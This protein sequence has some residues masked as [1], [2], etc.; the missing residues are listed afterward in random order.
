[1]P[2]PTCPCTASLDRCYRCDVLLGL[3]DLHLTH[4]EVTEAAGVLHV[5]ACD[6]L[7]GCP[8][9]G[10]IA[11]GHGR[12]TASL[13][14]APLAGR[15]SR[16]RWRNYRWLCRE[17]ACPVASFLEQSPQVAA[18]RGR[19]TTRAVSWAIRQLRY[20]NASIQGLARQLGTTWNTLWS[21]IRTR[22]T[23]AAAD[24][25]RFDGVEVLGVDKHVWHHA[26]PRRRGP[27]ELTGM[28]DL[29]RRRHPTAR[30]LDLVPG[31]SGTVYKDW[32]TA[33]GPS[34][35]N[36]IHTILR[37]GRERRT[38]RLYVRLQTALAAHEDRISVE[39]AYQCAQDV[40]DMFH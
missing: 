24:P 19:L 20:E 11:T 21:Q 16:L 13:I 34:F 7:T 3:P 40:R 38:E 8:G 6:P 28:V 36:D 30:L 23:D 25:A 10:V 37:A 35:R 5:E 2:H 14:D 4:T 17:T 22:L 31:R 18:P 33:R 27:K 32:L 1:M 29:S 9:C 26:N 12:V 15:P 39:V